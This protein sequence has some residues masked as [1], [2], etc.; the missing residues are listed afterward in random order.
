MPPWED[1]ILGGGVGGA[2]IQ[3]GDCV[4][5][6]TGPNLNSFGNS[7]PSAGGEKHAKTCTEA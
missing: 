7:G 3:A 4:R 6:D 2:S 5:E 1:L